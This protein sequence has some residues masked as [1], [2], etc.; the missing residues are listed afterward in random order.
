MREVEGRRRAAGGEV[1]QIAVGHLGFSSQTVGR[2]N[3]WAKLWAVQK[4][5]RPLTKVMQ[6]KRRWIREV[7]Q[8]RKQ[9]WEDWSV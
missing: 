1:A 8:V 3:S 6:R 5:E 4:K 9:S 7:Q 2:T